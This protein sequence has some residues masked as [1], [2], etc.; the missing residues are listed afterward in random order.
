MPSAL[1]LSPHLDDA[2]FSCAEPMLALEEAGWDVTVATVFTASVAEPA[3]FALACQLDK[4]LAADVDYM[5]LRRAEDRGCMDRLGVVWRHLGLPEAPHRGYESAAE[6]FGDVRPDDP[7]H[8]DVAAALGELLR[9]HAPDVCVAPLGIGGHVDHV[10]LVRCLA[11]LPADVAPRTVLRYADQPYALRH[12]GALEAV[13]DALPPHSAVRFASRSATRRRA[14]E[15][16]GAY[17]TQL[18]FQFGGVE[19]M[20]ATLDAAFAAGTRLWLQGAR[21]AAL[22]SVVSRPEPA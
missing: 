4:G 7:A 21:S 5:A 8:R 11:A 18:P 22:E 3:G 6:L 15:A 14:L 10:V 16:I 19:S 20:R 9:E 12:P 13:V 2:A 1:F 17:A